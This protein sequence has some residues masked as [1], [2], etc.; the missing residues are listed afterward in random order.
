MVFFLGDL[1]KY[2]LDT[3]LGT[4]L[5]EAFGPLIGSYWISL[6][7]FFSRH[8]MTDWWL[9]TMEFYDFPFSW[10]MLGISSLNHPNLTFT[11]IF[12]RGV[13]ARCCKY[14]F[15][16]MEFYDFP[17]IGNVIIPTDFHSNIFQRGCLNPPTSY[18]TWSI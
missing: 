13:L 12:S 4:I 18:G 2:L 1:R 7:P 15:G 17:S 3:N 9:G 10:E 8:T 14:W 6:A 5:S 16:T 11:K